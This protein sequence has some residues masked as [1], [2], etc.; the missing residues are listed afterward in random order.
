MPLA[1]GAL[2]ARRGLPVPTLVSI[3]L[4][5]QLLLQPSVTFREGRR[6]ILFPRSASQSLCVS[7]PTPVSD[8]TPIHVACC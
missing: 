5:D 8:M 1:G 2:T 4:G 7:P 6:N 3:T